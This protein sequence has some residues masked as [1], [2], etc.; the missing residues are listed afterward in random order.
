MQSQETARIL[1][2]DDDPSAR[3]IH[4]LLLEASGYQVVEDD[5]RAPDI[6]E[7]IQTNQISL[8]LLDRRMPD[9]DGFELL[10]EIREFSSPLNLPVVMFSTGPDSPNVVKALE[11][12]ANDYIYKLVDP[13]VLLARVESHLRLR[14]NS[15]SRLAEALGSQYRLEEKLGEGAC[16]VV[17]RAFDT[18]LKREVAIKCLKPQVARNSE[19]EQRFRREAEALARFRHRNVIEVFDFGTEPDSY[20]VTDFVP[21]EDLRD[22]LGSQISVE[23]TIEWIRALA[24]AL[25]TVHQHGLIHRD[26]KPSNVRI[27]PQGKPVLLD[28]GLCKM[29]HS[30]GL[31][32]TGVDTIIGTP[33][34]L[35][36]EQINLNLGP[37]DERADIHGLGLL[38]YEMLAGEPAFKG[39]LPQ[40]LHQTLNSMPPP[41]SELREDAD[42]R[43]D[44]LVLRAISKNPRDRIPTCGAF[45]EELSDV[46]R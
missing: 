31:S 14:A 15:K 10:R 36:P 46:S 18:V 5:G 19:F 17:Y 11:M 29:V 12:G 2:V 26:V 24:E 3:K 42:S 43:L 41:P 27:T 1:I 7:L 39:T 8:V 22:R 4:R 25:E 13:S 32:L 38:A 33:A 21:G 34:Y 35:A 28:F 45:L 37:V 30:E 9:R 40:M 23:Q 20:L 44:E 16:G 6:Q